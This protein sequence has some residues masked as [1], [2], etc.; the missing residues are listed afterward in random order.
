MIRCSRCRREQRSGPMSESSYQPQGYY[1]SA[2]QT[3]AA[4]RLGAAAADFRRNIEE[5]SERLG[6]AGA[7]LVSVSQQLATA[8][9]EA[10]QAAEQAKEAQRQAEQTQQQMQRDYGA[11]SGLVRDLQD[12]ISALATLARP[13]SLETHAEQPAQAN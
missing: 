3:E 7:Q 2:P 5:A 8:I 11:V 6:N 12:R 13:L 9:T 10:R 1:G 4:Q